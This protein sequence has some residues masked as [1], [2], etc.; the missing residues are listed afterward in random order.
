MVNDGRLGP[1]RFLQILKV[2][3]VLIRNAQTPLTLTIGGLT[4]LNVGF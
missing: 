4:F 1:P 3:W 2:L